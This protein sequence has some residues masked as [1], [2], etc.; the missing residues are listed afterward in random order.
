[1]GERNYA[2]FYAL[3]K[4]MPGANKEQLVYEYTDGRTPS[5]RVMKD[6]EY[7]QMIEAMEDLVGNKKELK[8]ECSVCLKLMQQLGIDT[9][10]WQR[11]DLF[12]ENPK[13]AGK[14]FRYIKLEELEQLELKLRSIHRKGG[15]QPVAKNDKETKKVVAI[16]LSNNNVIN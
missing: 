7:R 2:R 3:L 8:K 1:M 14:A 16:P 4:Q 13:I 15:L 10:D 12:C 11:V 9:T 5:L 6:K